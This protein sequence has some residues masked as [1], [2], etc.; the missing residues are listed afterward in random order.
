MSKI[1]NRICQ[2]R[3]FDLL[4]SVSFGLPG[5]LT[6]LVCF[7]HVFP[8]D[9]SDFVPGDCKVNNNVFFVWEIGMGGF[10]MRMCI[11]LMRDGERSCL[12][13]IS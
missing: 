12:F 5:S 7:S 4:P 6:T 3:V 11:R 10:D 13:L 1:L 8:A 2:Q 9:S